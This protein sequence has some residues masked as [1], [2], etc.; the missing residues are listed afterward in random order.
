[1]PHFCICTIVH[2]SKN[3][4]NCSMFVFDPHLVSNS[5]DS[6]HEFCNHESTN[7]FNENQEEWM[8]LFTLVVHK[9]KQTTS[10]SW[11]I[12]RFVVTENSWTH[13]VN[14]IYCSTFGFC[15]SIDLGSFY[16]VHENQRLREVVLDRS[17][18]CFLSLFLASFCFPFWASFPLR[19]SIQFRVRWVVEMAAVHR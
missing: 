6:F 17:F 18:F 13:L 12:R 7:F 14:S 8:L 16:S 19:S 9:N 15:D 10:V 5:S 4:P 1:M 11:K 2:W 3:E